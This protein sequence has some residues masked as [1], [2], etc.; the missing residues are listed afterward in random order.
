MALNDALLNIGADAMAAAVA[1]VSIHTADPGANGA[2]LSSAGKVAANWDASAN[3]DM[4]LT[5]DVSF[6]GGEASGA[7]TYVGLWSSADAWYGSIKIPTDGSND[8]T[9]NAAGEY[10]LTSITVTGTATDAG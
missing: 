5:D 1:K 8:L 4:L 7:A 2:N 3:G 10:T 6:T 9:F